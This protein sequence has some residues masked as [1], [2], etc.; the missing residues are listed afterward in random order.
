MSAFGIKNNPW[1]G[2]VF[3]TDDDNVQVE[4]NDVFFG[5]DGLLCK[6]Y[7]RLQFI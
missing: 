3:G 1:W 6:W 5:W 4:A 7:F 2:V